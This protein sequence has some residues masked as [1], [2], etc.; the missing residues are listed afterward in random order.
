MHATS[1]SQFEATRAGTTPGL[2]QVRDDVWALPLPIPG[3]YMSYSLQYLLR[4]TA[5]G[6]HIVDPGWDSNDNWQRLISALAEL[7][8]SVEDV[9]SITAT[10]IHPDHIGMAIRIREASGAR[11]QVL[12]AEVGSIDVQG[13]P[14]DFR[15]Q[16]VRDW[17][18]PEARWNE[19]STMLVGMPERALPSIDS[20]LQDDEVL[21]IPGFELV[22]MATPGH[23][24]GSLCLRDDARSLMFTGDHVL[25]MMHPGIGLGGPS[26]ANP[27]ADYLASL[28]SVSAYPEHEVLPGHGYRFTGLA[29]RAAKSA[30]HHLRRSREVGE[31]LAGDPGA[32]VWQVAKQLTWTSGWNKLAGFYL[33]SALSQTA[34][35]RD[36]LASAPT[37]AEPDRHVRFTVD[38]FLRGTE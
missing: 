38:T 5:G 14:A 31:V 11:V 36:Y 27:L 8:A 19:L 25:P 32:T 13:I 21:R 37:D 26:R 1:P 16:N 3:G 22:V 17:G 33:Y 6:I 4:D 2:E 12:D 20:T 10:H 18:V 9:R 28:A 34:M 15:D 30:A 23:T 7:G 35:H 29:E 24:P